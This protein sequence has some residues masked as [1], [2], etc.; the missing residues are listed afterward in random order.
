MEGIEIVND[1]GGN[2]GDP[3]AA[4]GAPSSPTSHFQVSSFVTANT[5]RMRLMQVDKLL[6]SNISIALYFHTIMESTL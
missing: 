2:L 4:T 3:L 6:A 5:M 1:V